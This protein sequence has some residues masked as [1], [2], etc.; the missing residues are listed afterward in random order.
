[1]LEAVQ[2]DVGLVLVG[3]HG[4]VGTQ[5]HNQKGTYDDPA[6]GGN[7]NDDPAQQSFRVVVSIPDSGHRDEDAP[8]A[9]DD[10]LEASVG[11]VRHVLAD[12]AL[13]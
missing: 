5:R 7:E 11:Q 13:R 1:M 6:D 3:L 2:G 12:G 9:V 4:Q 10:I 8:E